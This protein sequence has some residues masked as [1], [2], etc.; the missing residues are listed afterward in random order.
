MRILYNRFVLMCEVLELHL[1]KNKC[2]QRLL[3]FNFVMQKVKML[4]GT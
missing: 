4:A 1:N 2:S 3:F